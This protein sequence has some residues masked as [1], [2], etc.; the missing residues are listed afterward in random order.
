M[1][2]QDLGSIGELIGSIAVVISLI[3]LA[4]QIRQNTE[5][6]KLLATQNLVNQNSDLVDGIASD[7]VRAALI[8]KGIMDGLGDL[9]AEEELRFSCNMMAV[10]NQFELAY[11]QYRSGNLHSEIW[12]KYAYEI[13]IWISLPGGKEWYAKDHARYSPEFRK[14]FTESLL[15]YAPPAEIPTFGKETS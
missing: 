1:S 4:I 6:N 10:Y 9:T 3:Y 12:H 8:Q 11:H 15:N 2:I 14:Y 5:S 7:P 13:P